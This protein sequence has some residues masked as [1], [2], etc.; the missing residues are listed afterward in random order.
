MTQQEAEAL[1]RYE[2]E[3][4]KLFWKV[5]GPK[6]NLF[7]EAG[8]EST[9]GYRRIMLRGKMYLA[10]R[11]V[12][13]LHYRQL[14]AM[15]DHKDRN[16]RNNKIENLRESDFSENGL[17]SKIRS[18]NRHNTTGVSYEPRTG[19]FYA[20]FNC[21]AQTLNSLG[22]RAWSDTIGRRLVLKANKNYLLLRSEIEALGSG[23][24]QDRA[25]KEMAE[26]L[27]MIS[28]AKSSGYIP[29]G[30]FD[31]ARPLDPGR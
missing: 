17:N 25:W 2:P 5:P 12:W 31:Q 16:C 15:L 29:T 14:P 18:D 4:G 13:L 21:T 10:H 23:Q 6:R 24:E 11:I 19:K 28:T 27:D 8:H 30:R 7:K 3:T 1:F 26:T 20:R 9:S 22:H